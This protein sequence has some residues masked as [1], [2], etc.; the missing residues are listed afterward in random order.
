MSDHAD[1][2]IFKWLELVRAGGEA[3]AAA[4]EKLLIDANGHFRRLIKKRLD[5]KDER[6]LSDLVQEALMKLA[7]LMD[8]P[9]KV[10]AQSPGEFR[11]LLTRIGSNVIKDHF[12]RGIYAHDE[13]QLGSDYDSPAAG[14][15]FRTKLARQEFHSER[16]R[17][18]EHL[19]TELREIVRRRFVEGQT[20]ALIAAEMNLSVNK[21]VSDCRKAL[22]VLRLDLAHFGSG[23]TK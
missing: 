20:Y 17:A 4:E 12:R 18:L 2:E 21:V 19:P 11:S 23:E 6:H 3:A 13:P 9:A 8:Q 5:E 16:Q 14:T 1:D 15:T 10:R 22:K 7:K